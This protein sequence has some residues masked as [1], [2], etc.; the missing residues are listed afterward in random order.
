L[1]QEDVPQPLTAESGTDAPRVTEITFP[2]GATDKWNDEQRQF[3]HQRIRIWAL[4]LHLLAFVIVAR[5]FRFFEASSKLAPGP[6]VAMAAGCLGLLVL[7]LQVVLVRSP[8]QSQL[9]RLELLLGATAAVVIVSWSHTWLTL[10]IA[11]PPQSPETIQELFRG[12]YWVVWPDRT[13]RVQLPPA[14]LSFPVANYWI[15]FGGLYGIVVPNTRRRGVAMLIAVLLAAGATLAIGALANPALRP[16][17]AGNLFSCLAMVGIFSGLAL[18]I[19]LRFQAL[20]AEIFE[21]RRVGRY[22]LLRILGQ[23][24]MGEVYLAR[25]LLLRRPCAVKL[26]R[27]ERAGSGDWLLRFEREVQAMAQ[28]THPNTVEVYDFGRTDDGSFF[29]AM[30][31]LP[32]MTLDALVRAHGP[33]PPGRVVYLLLQVCGALGEAHRKGLVH[34]DVKPGNIFASERGGMRD[35]VK[36]LDFGLVHGQLEDLTPP[37]SRL[38]APPPREHLAPHLSHEG[39]FIGTPAYMAP[40][41]IRGE[42]PDARSDLY[43]LGCVAWFLLTGRPPFERNAL[44]Q[45]VSAPVPRLRERNP[46]LPEELEVI[47]TRCLAKEREARFQSVEELAAALDATVSAGQWDSARAEAWWRAHGLATGPE[48]TLAPRTTST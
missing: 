43:S 36:L 26:I 47:L 7:G 16:Y 33:L 12:V 28:L 2:Q 15:A 32:G 9:R 37:P 11:A 30:E 46:E 48:P 14:L 8:S 44:E 21:A 42:R 29:C 27:P 41:Q 3:L 17:L 39:Q 34:R 5:A 24:A 13:V 31:Y 20:R 22:R 25:H 19:S 18:Y 10:G 38:G 23:G 6:K 45:H 1:R 35:F 4:V 40:E